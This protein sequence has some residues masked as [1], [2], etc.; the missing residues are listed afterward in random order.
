VPPPSPPVLDNEIRADFGPSFALGRGVLPGTA[1]GLAM[2]T[3]IQ[4]PP[5]AAIE[6]G[7]RLWLPETEGG[8]DARGSFSRIDLALG[9]CPFITET[10]SAGLGVCAG[11]T[12]GVMTAQGSGSGGANTVNRP[13]LDI[14]GRAFGLLRVFAPLWVTGSATIATPLA[15]ATFYHRRGDGSEVDVWDMPALAGSVELGISLRLGP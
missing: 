13:V 7:S 10:A 8:T 5:W 3:V 11:L 9:W 12:G 15:P 4:L 6:V 2:R 14:H 1:V